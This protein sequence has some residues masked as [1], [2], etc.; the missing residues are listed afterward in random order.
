MPPEKA[1][2]ILYGVPHSLYTGKVRCYL[3]NQGIAYQERPTSHPDF[4][5]RIVPVLGRSII[6]V[7]ETPDGQIIQDSIDIIDYFESQGVPYPVYPVTPLQRALGVVIEYFGGQALRKHAMHY[8]WT[9]LQEQERFLRHA[10]VSGSGEEVA[11]MVMGRMQSYLPPLGVTEPTI[12]LIEASYI[13]LLDTLEGHFAVMP[14]LFGG[15]PSI[16]DYGLVASLF[17]HLG[18]DPVPAHIMRQRA[19]RVCRWVERMNAPGLDVVE[20]PDA[21]AEFVAADAVPVSLEPFLAHVADDIFPEL[22]DKLAFLDSWVATHA[23]S[24]YQP[25]ADRPHRRQLGMVRT[26][27][28]G[29]DIEVGVEPYLLYVLQRAVDALDGLGQAER[30]RV[31]DELQRLGLDQALPVERKYRV[32]RHNHVEVWRI[33][34]S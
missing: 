34:K 6:P 24:D 18:R 20:Y 30:R 27:Y 8:R 19:P 9:Y 32:A 23:I 7:L 1:P 14:Y 33:A 4:A 28:Y 13:K 29:A 5:A 22:T 31:W 17:A 25:V 26:R 3:R 10:F 16:G 21:R 12:P 15:R 2:Y 11:D